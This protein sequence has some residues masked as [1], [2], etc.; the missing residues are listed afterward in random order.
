METR[1]TRCIDIFISKY[2]ILLVLGSVPLQ[3]REKEKE[4]E[5]EGK[6]GERE[7]ERKREREKNKV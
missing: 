5:G 7:S 6:E 4:K 2:T 1:Y 3:E